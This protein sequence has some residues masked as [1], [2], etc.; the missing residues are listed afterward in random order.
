MGVG[1]RG[2]A[3]PSGPAGRC[4]GVGDARGTLALPGSTFG[5][6]DGHVDGQDGWRQRPFA[7]LFR[8]PLPSRGRPGSCLAWGCPGGW[9]SWG[10]TP[11][12]PPQAGWSLPGPGGT[13]PAGASVQWPVLPSSARRPCPA[14]SCSSGHP[15]CHP[16][17]SPSPLPELPPTP[18]I[19]PV[20]W[21]QHGCASPGLGQEKKGVQMSTRRLQ[22][23]PGGRGHILPLQPQ[24]GCSA[25]VPVGGTCS[26]CGLS[27]PRCWATGSPQHPDPG[28]WDRNAI[29]CW[30]LSS[31]SS[32]GAGLAPDTHRSKAL[33]PRGAPCHLRC[34]EPLSLPRASTHRDLPSCTK[35]H[36]LCP[37]P[38]PR[39]RPYPCPTLGTA[40][41]G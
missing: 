28:R 6:L 41:G 2:S 24:Q 7:A 10:K 8:N 11:E 17:T 9:R 37:C 29:P 21:Q 30:P 4:G 15:H 22:W 27:A 3:G 40:H 32:T 33:T 31:L 13:C 35:G 36:P 26:S 23:G 18:G 34:T 38:L 14:P 1:V 20:L 19:A 16:P 25:K 39:L 5:R 12:V